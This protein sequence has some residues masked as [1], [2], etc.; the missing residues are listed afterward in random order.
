[1]L[2]SGRLIR[3][4]PLA[5]SLENAFLSRVLPVESGS[6]ASSSLHTPMLA[7]F[8]LTQF[9]LSYFIAVAY[10]DNSID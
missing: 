6:K 10:I 7:P 5:A 1:M 8:S 4:D 3:S 9:K 2:P